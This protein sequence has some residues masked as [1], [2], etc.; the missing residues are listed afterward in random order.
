[1]FFIDMPPPSVFVC[2]KSSETEL[3]PVSVL[4]DLLGRLLWYFRMPRPGTRGHL[5]LSYCNTNSTQMSR[6]HH[7]SHAAVLL[8]L[9]VVI[10]Y[11]V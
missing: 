11:G 6:R 2:S 5:F 7:F 9:I 4:P 3:R 1:M 10:V 8:L